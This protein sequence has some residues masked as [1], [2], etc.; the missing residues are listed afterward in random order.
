MHPALPFT[1]S[2]F[3]PRATLATAV[4][5]FSQYGVSAPFASTH[6]LMRRGMEEIIRL[7][8]AP[9]P[10]LTH[11]TAFRTRARNGFSLSHPP[12]RVLS[13]RTLSIAHTFSIGLKSGEYGG[14][15]PQRIERIGEPP[16]PLPSQTPAQ[17]RPRTPVQEPPQKPFWTCRAL[18][19]SPPGRPSARRTYG[20]PYEGRRRAARALHSA[21]PWLGGGSARAERAR[22]GCEKAR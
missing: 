14:S 15:F 4:P 17:R 7:R 11:A 12:G 2:F 10:A 8:A 13:I 21:T 19:A 1:H 5:T 6:A 18:R 20:P 9:R 16:L 3:F 22:E